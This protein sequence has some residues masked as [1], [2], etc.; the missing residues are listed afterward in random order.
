M[1]TL[2]F[3]KHS[4]ALQTGLEERVQN[5]SGCEEISTLPSVT[6]RMSELQHFWVSWW[7]PV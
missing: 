1:K 7:T 5:P 3:Q 6:K 4:I 2:T